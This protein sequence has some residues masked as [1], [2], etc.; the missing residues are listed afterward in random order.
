MI[1]AFFC[2][3][4]VRREGFAGVSAIGISRINGN[5]MRHAKKRRENKQ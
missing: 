4:L 5:K 1:V 2:I 3:G